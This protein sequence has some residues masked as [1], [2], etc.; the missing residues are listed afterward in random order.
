MRSIKGELGGDNAVR[1]YAFL[2]NEDLSDSE[3]I[4]RRRELQEANIFPIWYDGDHDEDIEALL[5][6]LA[7]D[8]RTS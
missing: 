3:R 1:H 2:S 6:L 8:R 7:D 4:K 5:E